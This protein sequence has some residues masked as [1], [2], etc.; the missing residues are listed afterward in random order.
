MHAQGSPDEGTHL[1]RSRELTAGGCPWLKKF[2]IQSHTA[3][4]G[5][6]HPMTG[7]QERNKGLAPLCHLRKYWAWSRAS[8]ET[9]KSLCCDCIRVHLLPPFTP[10]SFTL[11][12]MLISKAFSSKQP[13]QKFTLQTFIQGDFD[14]I[15]YPQEKL[16]QKGLRVCSRAYFKDL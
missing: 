12:Q 15:T 2:L 13:T 16:D 1:P 14:L 6:P 7:Q 5:K 8:F 10:A 11:L 3:C 9:H 4:M